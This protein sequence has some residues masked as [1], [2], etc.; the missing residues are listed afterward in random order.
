MSNFLVKDGDKA[1]WGIPEGYPGK[2]ELFNIEWDGNTEGLISVQNV[3]A[4]SRMYK[5]SDEMPTNEQIRN[6]TMT[7]TMLDQSNSVEW[8]IDTLSQ[9]I[10][11]DYWQHA[12]NNG[13]ITEK[14]CL[15]AF[16]EGLFAVIR[17]KNLKISNLTF[18]ETGTYFLKS[19]AFHG[20]LSKAESKAIQ[21][22]SEE[23]LPKNLEVFWITIDVEK[24]TIDKTLDE[25]NNAYDARK[26]LIAKRGQEIWSCI[27][28]IT[29]SEGP[30]FIRYSYTQNQFGVQIF[31]PFAKFPTSGLV[32]LQ[33]KITNNVILN[34]STSG[35]A[36]KFK[37]TVDDSGTLSA[38]E[39]TA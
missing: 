25:V 16:D 35:S 36:K 6:I 38:T 14:G 22:I 29:E 12:T 10:G 30:R 11:R 8:T 32:E 34:S 20:Y 2:E 1:E 27:G 23:F 17:E 37:I 15:L 9:I 21:Y 28:R 33:H 3:A 4:G 5:V 31:T 7:V 24:G 19:S 39:V 26:I 13:L 18:P